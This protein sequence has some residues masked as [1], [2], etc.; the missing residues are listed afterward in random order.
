MKKSSKVLIV[1]L[2]AL[3]LSVGAYAFADSNTVAA[4]Q[5]GDGQGDISGYTISAVH[6]T[7]NDTNPGLIDSVSFTISPAVTATT[8]VKI[9]LVDS[10]STWYT[11]TPGAGTSVT[12]PTTGADV[13]SADMLRVVAAN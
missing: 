12:C 7:L 11:C 10:G 9:K 13:L 4:S 6:Y 2:L 8:V 5:A 1:L 3:I